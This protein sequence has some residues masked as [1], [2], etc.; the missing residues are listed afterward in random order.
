MEERIVTIKNLNSP[1][2]K[3]IIAIAA[4]IIIMTIALAISSS[5]IPGDYKKLRQNLRDLNYEVETYLDK[6]DA[7]MCFTMMVNSLTYYEDEDLEDEVDKIYE[8]LADTTN[9]SD[10][11]DIP[12]SVDCAVMAVD[13][14]EENFIVVIYFDDSKYAKTFFEM[15][16][17]LLEFIKENGSDS[18]EFRNIKRDD[19]VFAQKDNIVYLGTKNAV[20]DS[21]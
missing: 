16:K 15:C 14:Y 18:Y 19:F 11:E 20:K 1:K 2:I 10:V 12:K 7:L 6:D 17:P 13:E 4:V 8:N 9:E 3:T 5:S 21:Q